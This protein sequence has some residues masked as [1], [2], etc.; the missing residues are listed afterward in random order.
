[1]GF[2]S[3]FS[4]TGSAD[5]TGS[6]VITADY[7]VHYDLLPRGK[8]AKKAYFNKYY[9]LFSHFHVSENCGI[10][11]QR[12]SPHFWLQTVEQEVLS[13]KSRGVESRKHATK[14]FFSCFSSY[15]II[16]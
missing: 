13:V 10:S 4:I 12:P 6:D 2:I 7:L 9:N 8:T 16:I 14:K 11:R 5:R 15:F 1:M 3:L